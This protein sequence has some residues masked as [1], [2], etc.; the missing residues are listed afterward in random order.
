MGPN[1]A[2]QDYLVGARVS[3]QENC[4]M[5]ELTPKGPVLAYQNHFVG[6]LSTVN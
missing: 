4:D 5:R 3:H 6:S 2:Y 1:L